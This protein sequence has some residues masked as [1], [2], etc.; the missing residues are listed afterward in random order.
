MAF[1][2]RRRTKEGDDRFLGIYLDVHGR[3]RSAG[4]FST[5]K[6]ALREAERQEE[7]QAE[8]RVG[9]VRDGKQYFRSYVEE[10]WLPN[11]L[12]EHSTRQSYVYLL[13]RY[14]LPVFGSMRMARI[15][16]GNV[17]QWVVDLQSRNVKPPT[18][19]K[20]KVI[21]DAIFTTA[22]NDQITYLHAG[23][24]VKTPPVAKKPRRIITAAQ[25]EAIYR[26]LPNEMMRLLVETDIESGLRWGELT[27][28]RLN[29]LDFESGMLTV[30]R[31]VVK[32]NSK[33]HPEG[34]RYFVKD[35]PKDKEWRQLKLPIHLV[36]KLAAFARERGLKAGDLLFRYEPPG[37]ASR[38][39]VP[40]ELPDPEELGWTAPNE[41][42]RTYRH[43][44]TTAY[45]AGRCRCRHCRD[46]IAVYRAERRAAG[47]DE[48]RQRRIVH[49]DGHI[50]GDWFRP[51]VW[52]PAVEQAELGFHVTPHGLRHAH[53]SWLLAGG[54]DVQ[55]VKERLGHGSL[56][57]TARYLGTLP[58]ADD[59]ALAALE[60][61]RGKRATDEASGVDPGA[62][63][64]GAPDAAEKDKKIAELEAKLARFK[65]LLED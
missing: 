8:G 56:S 25:F 31:V 61:I 7:R 54:A 34:K 60:K 53:A 30:A 52:N 55:V 11:H 50:P 57:T 5:E 13:N 59:A 6:Q 32:L 9:S 65:Q 21:L 15:M 3:E 58:G 38:R 35:Y 14:I 33:F 4:A 10:T 48:P 42:G 63:A 62:S 39:V 28:L 20:C 36:A 12:I 49:S 41:K 24:G 47:M 44:T 17:R 46:A 16:P 26:G 64:V 2:R 1:T 37:E 51:A 27:E 18:I 40:E 22:L 23:R 45:A 19:E 29:D 43:G